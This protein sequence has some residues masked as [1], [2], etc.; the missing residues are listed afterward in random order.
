MIA[1]VALIAD[2]KEQIKLGRRTHGDARR[3]CI[4]LQNKSL[5]RRAFAH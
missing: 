4:R 5:A 3:H 1:V 2:V